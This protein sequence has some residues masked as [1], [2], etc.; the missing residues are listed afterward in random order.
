MLDSIKRPFPECIELLQKNIKL[1]P[2]FKLF[3]EWCQ[4]Q[5]IPVIVLSSGM[6]P[7]IRQLLVDLVG[8]SAKEIEIISNQVHIMDDGSWDIVYHDDR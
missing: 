4:T 1:D 8:P 6:E 3:Y 7:I 2:G 5:N